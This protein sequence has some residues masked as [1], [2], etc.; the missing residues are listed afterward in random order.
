[1]KRM[2]AVL[3]AL[4]IGFAGTLKADEGMWLLPLIKKL[5]I[6]KMQEK[7]LKLSAEEIYSVN[8]SSLKDAIVIFG[9]GCT[10]ELISDQGLI[11][12]NHHCGYG[13]I[14]ELSSVED[15]YLE[16]GFW[17]KSLEEE[18]PAPG[19]SVTFMKR[20]EDVTEKIEAG[21]TDEMS[22]VQRMAAVDS[23]SKHI[24][25]SVK[26]DTHYRTLVRDFYGGN[27]YY[28][29]VYEVF[30]DV[31]FVGAPPSSIGKFGHDTDN[32]MWPR[33]TGDF[34][35]FRVYADAEGN[36]AEYSPEN[37]PLK[38]AHHLPI[39]LKGYEKDDFAM[40]LG[41]PGSTE[42]YLTSW[43]IDE[44]VN[45]FNYSLINPRG[46]KQEIWQEAMNSSEKIRLQYAS[47]YSRSSNYWKNSIGMNRGLKNLNV[48]A[49]KQKLEEQFSEWVNENADRKAKYGEVLTELE[50]AYSERAPFYLA[51]NFVREC[52][53]RGTEI[54]SFALSARD[55]EK[56]LEEEDEEKISAAVEALKEA[57]KEFYKDYHAA[58]DQK[59]M[60]ALFNLYFD[61]IDAKFYPSFFEDIKTEKE[62]GFETFASKLF[63]KSLFVNSDDFNSFLENP[64]LKT[65]QKDPAYKA[66]KST[67]DLYFSLWE[68]TRESNM[69][70]TKN[71]RLFIAG[72]QAM[73]PDKVYY[74]DANFSM[75]LSYGEVGDYEARDAVIY[76]HYTTLKGVME[77]EKPDDYEFAVPER[78]KELYESKDYG[79]YANEDGRMYVNFTTDNDITGGNSGSPVIN[80]EG[81]LFGLAFDGNWEAMSGDIAFE[82]ELQKCINV[83]IRYVLFIIDK[84]AGATNLIDEMTIV[85]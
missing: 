35:M 55:L 11:L 7:G 84:Y 2:T 69:T 6:E 43:G 78:L 66:G 20:M 51:Q 19:L 62:D 45:I 27:Q 64:K 61:E 83:D 13:T 12:T 38:P 77:K 34:S 76:K 71:H 48:I 75:R 23:I 24:A 29:I 58:T 15:N 9:G 44:R 1:M 14:Q 8:Q 47:K 26:G 28:L 50:T 41:F 65:L 3:V 80:G 72:L 68:K 57:G 82:Q 46:V 70:I 42:R 33:H 60:S 31:R 25:D 74:D 39:S 30:N 32:W 52:M 18:I 17:A 22:E 67:L 49:K 85:E 73:N 5:N 37:K 10:G 36:P 54:L 63:K 16:D 81:H 53:L 4:V 40:T 21:L 56:A 79:R 59:V